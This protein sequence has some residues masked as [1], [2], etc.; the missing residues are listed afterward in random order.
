PKAYMQTNT[1]RHGVRYHHNF[2]T[3]PLL[4]DIGRMC[5]LLSHHEPGQDSKREIE[6]NH[7]EISATV[8]YCCI[9]E[10]SPENAARHILK[11]ISQNIGF[12]QD[13]RFYHKKFSEM[14]ES[15][16]LRDLSRFG[17]K[18]TASQWRSIFEYVVNELGNAEH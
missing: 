17:A 6:I 1:T 8:A 9:F 16:P 2:P 15:Y 18:F 10:S 12:D 5:R 4:T 7:Q 3:K 14:L 13:A 11:L